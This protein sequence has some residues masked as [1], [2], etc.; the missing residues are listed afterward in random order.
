MTR[1]DEI[2]ARLAIL[3]AKAQ[4]LSHLVAV[5][6]S[7]YAAMRLKSVDSEIARLRVE[8]KTR[9]GELEETD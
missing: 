4:E 6:Q 7:W 2:L 8:L 9:E 3:E 5:S 1:H